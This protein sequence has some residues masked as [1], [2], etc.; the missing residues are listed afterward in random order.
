MTP[1]LQ[2]KVDY[3]A[4]ISS[5]QWRAR[6]R[7]YRN[8]HPNCELCGCA[9]KF[10]LQ[11]HH[12]SY[13]NLGKEK[14]E[15]LMT[16]CKDCHKKIEAIKSY[17]PAEPV[18][19][20]YSII[21]D[22]RIMDSD[23][24]CYSQIYNMVRDRYMSLYRK[25]QYGQQLEDMPHYKVVESEIEQ[26]IKSFKSE[27]VA[28]Y[29]SE[30]CSPEIELPYVDYPYWR[31]DYGDCLHEMAMRAFRG[32][33]GCDDRVTYLK[34]S[35]DDLFDIYPMLECDN[36]SHSEKVFVIHTLRAYCVEVNR[37]Y[38]DKYPKL[39]RNARIVAWVLHKCNDYES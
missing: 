31:E 18:L 27:G 28:R 14:D 20:I 13:K 21:L 32:I 7:L 38:K 26:Y 2:K 15:D 11:T 25:P 8:S 24:G 1:G 36:L 12:I 6:S 33:N 34:E 22:T 16:V 29:E 19:P 4:Y 17:N 30:L 37:C 39:A 9:D 10:K 5:P 3:K 23:L 35:G